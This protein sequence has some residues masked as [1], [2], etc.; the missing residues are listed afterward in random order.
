MKKLYIIFT[1]ISIVVVRCTTFKISLKGN[2]AD[3][4]EL[5]FNF[6]FILYPKVE[7]TFVAF[8]FT[9]LEDFKCKV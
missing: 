1:S 7:R 8:H 4:S 2:D 6:P 3:I 9:S 5:R